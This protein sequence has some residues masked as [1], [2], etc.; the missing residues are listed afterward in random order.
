MK[1]TFYSPIWPVA[2]RIVALWVAIVVALTLRE[3]GDRLVP[4]LWVIALLGGSSF[5][6]AALV[7]AACW[8][9]I[10]ASDEEGQKRPDAVGTAALMSHCGWIMVA[11]ASTLSAGRALPEWLAALGYCSAVI[12]FG[13]GS[14]LGLAG[15]VRDARKGRAL[16]A[17]LG[18]AYAVIVVVIPQQRAPIGRANTRACYANQKTLAGAIEMYNLDKNTLR[19]PVDAAF[20]EALKS[21]GY[22]QSPPEDPGEGP[23]T[24]SHYRSTRGGNRVTCDVHGQIQ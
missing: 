18:A 9:D 14:L 15:A 17:S 1:D 11:C 13:A 7:T 19:E 20:L 10:R 6:A 2:H 12:L 3:K 22:L 8:H 16:L 21:G 23:R 24:G 4:E 5:V